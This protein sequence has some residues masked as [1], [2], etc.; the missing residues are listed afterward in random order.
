MKNKKAEMSLEYVAAIILIAVVIVVILLFIFNDEILNWVRVLPGYQLPDEDQIVEVD[1]SDEDITVEENGLVICPIKI[2][3]ILEG[4]KFGGAPIFFCGDK[5]CSR[6][7]L[8]ESKI[9]WKGADLTAIIEVEQL[10]DDKIGE[11][12]GGVVTIDSGVLSMRGSLYREVRKD[13]PEHSF[14]VNLHQSKF[15]GG[16]LCKNE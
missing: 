6:D 13:L 9:K 11:V 2:G 12:E 7:N 10:W 8:I 4:G 5:Q 1:S 3:R 15:E 14:V 16:F